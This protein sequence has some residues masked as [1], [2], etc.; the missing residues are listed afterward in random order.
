MNWKTWKTVIF[1]GA[2]V[3][4][5]VWGVVDFSAVYPL[6]IL[7]VVLIFTLLILIDFVGQRKGFAGS[8]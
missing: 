4:W 7:L 5:V 1:Y 3:L 6:Q 8:A 2:L